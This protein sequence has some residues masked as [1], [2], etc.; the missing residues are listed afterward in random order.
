MFPTVWSGSDPC[1]APGT[2]SPRSLLPHTHSWPGAPQQ[3]LW[4]PSTR[5]ATPDKV[6]G[7]W[8][9]RAGPGLPR[10]R[11][12]P[13]GWLCA[14]P[15]KQGATPGNWGQ[16]AVSPRAELQ[17]QPVSP[18]GVRCESGPGRP[19]AEGHDPGP[20][21][22]EG[23]KGGLGHLLPLL[24]PPSASEA[25]PAPDLYP[26]LS[27]PAPCLEPL[28]PLRSSRGLHPPPPPSTTAPPPPFSASLVRPPPQHPSPSA[29]L[30]PAVGP[31]AAPV[32]ESEDA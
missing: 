7:S 22:R 25:A 26:S 17:A 4:R 30:P 23:G 31:R 11:T 15:P 5:P 12:A 6:V 10:R 28:L 8:G 1:P 18:L 32:A 2:A 24:P 9:I 3:A 14:G 13:S 29:A 16:A 19:W 27:S 20:L 21:T